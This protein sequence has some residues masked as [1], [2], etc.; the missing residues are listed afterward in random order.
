MTIPQLV[1]HVVA[2]RHVDTHED[3]LVQDYLR[4]LRKDD[5]VVGLSL[6]QCWRVSD[7]R[8]SQVA[9]HSG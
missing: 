6:T 4:L 9:L 8:D 3:Y 5:D 7:I 2:S 1:R